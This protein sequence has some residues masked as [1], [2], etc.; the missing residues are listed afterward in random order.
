MIVKKP[1]LSDSAV[2][3]IR[4]GKANESMRAELKALNVKLKDK[5]K[6]IQYLEKGLE[7]QRIITQTLRTY[8]VELRDK[9]DQAN[10]EVGQ[11]RTLLCAVRAELDT[12]TRHL[13]AM[14]EEANTQ[15]AAKYAALAKVRELEAR[16]TEPTSHDAE[17]NELTSQLGREIRS[18]EKMYRAIQRVQS[19]LASH[20]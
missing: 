14:C 4:L 19:I 16:L 1:V 8:N 18:Q 20:T 5:D 7:G 2:D 10:E 9:M 6:R 17:V 12:K 15:E 11:L 3:I 13:K